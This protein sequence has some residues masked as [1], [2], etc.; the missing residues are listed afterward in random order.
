MTFV[1]PA[2]SVLAAAVDLHHLLGLYR[3]RRGT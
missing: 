3:A 2:A 1:N